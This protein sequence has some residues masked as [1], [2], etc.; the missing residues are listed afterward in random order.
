MIPSETF[1]KCV[2][3]GVEVLGRTRGMDVRVD[4]AMRVRVPAEAA[5]IMREEWI[6][7]RV[8]ENYQAP[9]SEVNDDGELLPETF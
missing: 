7:T 9:P 6:A 8:A 2:M 3:I 1:S 4:A 5:D